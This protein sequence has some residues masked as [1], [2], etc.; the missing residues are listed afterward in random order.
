MSNH[1]D[2]KVSAL[3]CRMPTDAEEPIESACAICCEPK[4][5]RR[6]HM[7][8]GVCSDDTDKKSCLECY[9]KLLFNCDDLSCIALHLKCP[10]CRMPMQQVE[11]NASALYGSNAYNRA[12][13]KL[14][15]VHL[16]DL[17]LEREDNQDMLNHAVQALTGVP[18]LQNMSADIQHRFLQRARVGHQIADSFLNAYDGF[19]QFRRMHPRQSDRL[20]VLQVARDFERMVQEQSTDE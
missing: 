8:C 2:Y 12:A 13:A 6:L 9:S 7:L 5:A 20:N 4:K 3:L 16:S 1:V 19:Q 10:W 14:R 18:N 17:V 15:H 11:L